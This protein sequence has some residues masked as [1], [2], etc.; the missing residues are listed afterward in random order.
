MAHFAEIDENNVVLRVIV[1]GNEDTADENGVEVESIGAAFCE[2]LLGGNWVQASY[3]ARDN[4]FRKQF[5]AKNFTYDPDAD[6]FIIPQLH[7]LWVLDEN[8]NWNAPTPYPDDGKDY[9]W[10]EDTTSWLEASS[11]S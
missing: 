3:N 1:V 9:L 4:G 10:D 6:V 7:P 2:N 11:E 5:P 8:H